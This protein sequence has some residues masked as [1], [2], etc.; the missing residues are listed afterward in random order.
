MPLNVTPPHNADTQG[1]P[2]NPTDLRAKPS[3]EADKWQRFHL[4]KCKF[5][6]AA[7]TLSRYILASLFNMSN[8]LFVGSGGVFEA[9]PG[10]PLLS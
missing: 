7:D 1:L 8:C 9:A 10:C 4:I 3:K 2:A 5:V 6:P